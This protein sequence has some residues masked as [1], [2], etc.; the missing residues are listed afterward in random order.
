[1]AKTRAQKEQAVAQ[2]A[3]RFS[4]ATSATFA[5]VSG[6]TMPQADELRQKAKEQGVNVFIA[7]KT[8]LKL[9]A[10]KAGIENLDPKALEGSIMTATSDDEVSAAKLIKEFGKE[11]ESLTIVGGVLEGQGISADEAI[12]LA[13]LPTKQE[14]YAQLL[15]VFNG[16]I[17]GFTRVLAGN[18][19]GLV[20]VLDGIAKQK[21]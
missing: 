16:P 11:K 1:M 21:A 20:T 10:E 13:S 9:A 15:S 2:I 12:Q 8:L 4:S 6:L 3:E 7:K 18:T 19:R 14:L 5:Q 17:G